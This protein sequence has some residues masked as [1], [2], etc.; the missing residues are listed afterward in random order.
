[1][2]P[3]T[4]R[5][6][7]DATRPERC[8]II[9]PVASYGIDT[10]ELV[11]DRQDF[12]N[13]PFTDLPPGPWYVGDDPKAVRYLVRPDGSVCESNEMPYDPATGART[14]PATGEVYAD[15]S[16]AWRVGTSDAVDALRDAN[17]PAA[18]PVTPEGK[19]S[20]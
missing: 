16:P 4:T 5:P 8:V 14:D 1:M 3:E 17:E 7:P 20:P 13:G 2:N 15:D 18:P 19:D 11:I 10:R 12:P 6:L 9:A